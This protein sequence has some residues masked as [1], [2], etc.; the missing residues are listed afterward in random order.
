MAT[1]AEPFKNYF[2]NNLTPALQTA[3]KSIGT[4]TSGLGD[5][6][7]LVFGQLWD[8]VIFPSLD[9]MITTVLPLLTDQWTATAEVMTTLFE[10]VKTIFDEV[11]V[12]GVM[13]ILTTLQGVWS[14]LWITSAKLWAQYG[15][16]TMEAIQSLI[17]SVGDTVLTVYKVDTG[18][19]P[20]YSGYVTL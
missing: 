14:D 10:T 1:L 20:L 4:I 12:T 16:P 5:T 13:P 8:N 6:F 3:F 7:N 2:T 19:S 11:F 15:E 17:T 18:Y 9:T